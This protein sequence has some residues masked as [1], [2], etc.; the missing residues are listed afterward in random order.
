QM[1]N[2]E[3]WPGFANAG[4]E[5]FLRDEN[6]RVI[7]VVAYGNSDY[8]GLGWQ[9]GPAPDV[10]EGKVLVR[11]YDA[12]AQHYQDTNTSD[13]WLGPFYHGVGQSN[14]GFQ[15]FEF[16]GTVIPFVSPENTFEVISNE[17]NTAKQSI[18]INVYQLTHLKFLEIL[19]AA[20]TR[21][22]E[23]RL[24]L[25]G[26]PVGWN[27]TN[28]DIEDYKDSKQDPFTEKYIA[29]RL[30]QKGAR[31]IFLTDKDAGDMRK[32]YTYNHAKYLIIDEKTLILLSGN[33]KP[34]SIP[35]DPSLGYG[36]REWGAVIHNTEVAGYFKNVFEADWLPLNEYRND[37]RYFESTHPTYGAPP[38]Y[39]E[40]QPHAKSGWYQPL[41][42]LDYQAFEASDTYK[43]SPVL[44]PDTSALVEGSITGTIN[45]AAQSVYVN[46][47]DINIDWV[48][49]RGGNR[50]FKFNWSDEASRFLNWGDGYEHHSQY[51]QALVDA[52]MR[53]CDVKI[54]VDSRFSE[55]NYEVYEG[56]QDNELDN[57]DTILYINH[58]AELLGIE[59]KLEARLCHLGGLSKV[60][61]KGLI[62]DSKIVLVSSINWNFNSVMNNREAALLIEN[63]KFAQFFET[64][65][66]SDW[67]RSPSVNDPSPPTS[68]EREVL[69]TEV[70]YDTY[71]SYEPEEFV[72]I[73]NPTTSTVDLSGWVLTDQYTK[74]TGYE[75]TLL[76]PNDTDLEAGS[77]VYI[78]KNASA[79][80]RETGFK[81]DF[82][83]LVDSDPEVSNLEIIDSS[84]ISDFRGPSLSNNGDEVVLANEFLFFDYTVS[85]FNNAWASHIINV[86]CYGASKYYTDLPDHGWALNATVPLHDEGM[87]YKRNIEETTGKYFDTD[88]PQDWDTP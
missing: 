49:S 3:D 86:V 79:F 64:V 71:L 53:G 37:T 60:H 36:N 6:R 7:D 52:A 14:F 46:Q 55:F 8:F 48:Y 70:Y 58:L 45:S 43:V 77:A 22:V 1:D 78:A 54:L 61:N 85:E 30:S 17:L 10:P 80:E 29:N 72:C 63:A 81:P 19:E 84:T 9:S 24:I 82:E 74:Y 16:T 23:V 88:T 35:A 2:P 47:A 31:V 32:R 34:S 39:F 57:I 83:F 44:S 62:V 18:W 68:Q 56:S 33:L 69:I 20:L 87:I 5:V 15:T 67:S 76:F 38:A 28:V 75:G 21:G 26:E 50:H 11:T 12:Q 41:S 27:L 40:P 42:N 73:T 66:I 25:E 13:D 4:D 59:T 65:F 51:L